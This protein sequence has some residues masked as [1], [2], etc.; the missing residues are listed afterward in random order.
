MELPIE[1]RNLIENELNKT[2]VKDLQEHAANI[3]YRYRNESGK[4]RRLLT[5]DIEA[6]SYVIVRMPATY[7]AVYTSLENT[8]DVF[9]CEIESLLDVG[10]GTGAGTWAVNELIILKSVTCLERE[11]AMINIGQMLMHNSEEEVLKNA[12]WKKCDL[13]NSDISE[14]ADLVICSYVL[15]EMNEID[16]KNVL[17]KL[18]N[19]TNK[20]LLIVEPGT[21]IGFN[22]IKVIRKDLIELGGN[23]IAPCPNVENCPISENDWCHCTC[24]VS[25]TKAHKL[26]KN[27]DVPYE[28]EKFSY[29]SCTKEV[30]EKEEFVRVLR[31][32]II[33][34]GKIT[35]QLCSRNGIYE[36]VITK[37]DK[38]LYKI[39][40][41]LKCGDM[42]NI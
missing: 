28:D 13:I 19:A 32:P 39:A 29:L 35:L 36:K 1:L 18:W 27:G 5:Q 34:S 20:M 10:A 25:R 33:E 9:C 21:P 23:I 11:D 4:G 41:K 40:R 22:E 17:T 14:K 7:G 38:Q 2:S 26:L 42:I 15:N 3:S 12:V 24:R 30:F 16:R 6:L 31:H 37:K 8:L